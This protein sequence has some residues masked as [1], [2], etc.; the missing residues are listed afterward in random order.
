MPG[1]LVPRLTLR[2]AAITL[3]GVVLLLTALLLLAVSSCYVVRGHTGGKYDP[4]Q[5]ISDA[6]RPEAPASPLM[7]ERQTEPH[8][9]GLHALRAAYRG[10]GLDPDA[11]DLRFRLGVDV[12]AV[13]GDGTSTGTLPPDLLRVLPQDG[14]AYTLLDLDAPGAEAQ[15]RGHLEGGDVA[16]AIVMVPGLHWVAIDR[17]RRDTLRIVDSLTAEPYEVEAKS[18]VDSH[19][20]SVVLI[21]PAGDGEPVSRSRSHAD[22]LAEMGQLNERRKVCR[23]LER[24]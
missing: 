12:N 22:G 17:Q 8:T 6:A 24:P 7:P 9:C 16:L 10:Y 14:F 3:A 15:L 5:G 11:Y 19:A 21:R 18:L 13:P 2:R 4:A 23:P 20:L 1:R